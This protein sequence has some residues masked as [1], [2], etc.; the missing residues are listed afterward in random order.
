MK[1][2]I[3][4]N[5][6]LIICY[7]LLICAVQAG[8][9]GFAI[10]TEPRE[11]EIYID[12]QLKTNISPAHLIISEGK[13][14]VEVRKAGMKTE[15]F[16]IVMPADG[17]LVK[18]V[19]L[20]L[21]PP[22]APTLNTVDATTQI[23][24]LLYPV[25]D[26][27]ETVA[28][29]QQRRENLLKQFNE[30][31][32]RHEIAFQAGVATLDKRGYNIENNMFPMKIEWSTWAKKFNL[33]DLSTAIITRD[34]AKALWTEGAQ[35]PVF[36]LMRLEKDTVTPHRQFIMATAT[37][38]E[39]TTAKYPKLSL[40]AARAIDSIAF[41]G[42]N[43]ILVARNIRNSLWEWDLNSGQLIP[44]QPVLISEKLLH[45]H[46]TKPVIVRV[47]DIYAY[48]ENLQTGKIDKTFSTEFFKLYDTAFSPDGQILAVANALQITLWNIDTGITT[49]IFKGF[50]NPMVR[51][52]YSRDGKT[53]ATLDSIG[54]IHIIDAATGKIL[55]TVEKDKLTQEQS[56]E[57]TQKYY[58]SLFDDF[59]ATERHSAKISTGKRFVILTDTTTRET[60]LLSGQLAEIA[61]I[62][63]SRD[64]QWLAAGRVDG[65]I[66]LWKLF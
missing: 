31:V 36:L 48:L 30:A 44:D 49:N 1:T 42:D 28:E 6:V 43:T 59:S 17:T 16:E 25:R 14:L 23:E 18:E 40:K 61:V 45:F 50:D 12:G 37:Q 10:T 22:P 3:Y 39:W 13:H 21:A 27:F 29:F 66:D 56:V 24:N 26:E 35:K 60:Y 33:Q 5:L 47:S 9:G 4:S 53:L 57:G 34:E 52:S 54:K 64:G 65:T 7:F 63:F 32:Q 20:T 2:R 51:M 38:R 41:S 58:P 55:N 11:A 46:P 15:Q 8:E 19:K 62:T